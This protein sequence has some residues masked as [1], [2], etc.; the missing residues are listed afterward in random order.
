MAF[1]FPWVLTPVVD[2]V[3]DVE[4]NDHNDPDEQILWLTLFV[5][6]L[7]QQK[8]VAIWADDAAP[9][10]VLDILTRT[11]MDTTTTVRA[12]IGGSALIPLT[13]TNLAAPGGTG[14]P[15]LKQTVTVPSLVLMGCDATPGAKT[16]VKVQLFENAHL[17]GWADMTIVAP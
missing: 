5:Q 6:N 11:A 3:D 15:L 4:D 14:T 2:G 7:K 13:G 16:V 9:G 1:I 17:V 10:A 12:S 8:I